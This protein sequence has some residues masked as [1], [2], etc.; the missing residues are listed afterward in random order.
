LPTISCP[1]CQNLTPRLLD[2][3]S[4]FAHVNYYRCER[5]GLVW[6]TPKSGDGPINVVTQPQDPS[7]K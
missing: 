2:A 4:Q 7:K 5:C 1:R 6:T 3:T